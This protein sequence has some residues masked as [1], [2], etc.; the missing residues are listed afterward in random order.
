MSW[1]SCLIFNFYT[2]SK[3]QLNEEEEKKG[4]EQ[5][6]FNQIFVELWLSAPPWLGIVQKGTYYSVQRKK[7]RT[8]EVGTYI[9]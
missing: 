8:N 3:Q 5:I 7:K 4:E 1:N 6:F 9:F 2:K